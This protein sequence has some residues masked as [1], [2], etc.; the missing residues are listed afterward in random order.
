[1]KRLLARISRGILGNDGARA[2]RD[3]WI[4]A[5]VP[6]R[7]FADVGGLWGT[8]NEKISVA[9][10]AGA[11]ATTMIDVQAPGSKWWQLF[12]QRCRELGVGGYASVTAD[13]CRREV[14][15]KLGRFDIVHCSGIM[16]HVPDML[17]FLRNLHHIT[18]SHLILTSMV[19][20]E[21]VR[22]SRGTLRLPPGTVLSVP[23]MGADSR[24]VMNRHFSD[25]DISIKDITAPAPRYLDN[26]LRFRTGP[27]WWLY[28]AAT[29]RALAGV[30]PFELVD[31]GWC[32]TGKT[33]SLLLRARH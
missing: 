31:E 2:D 18:G 16:Y 28:S 23:A 8:V 30:L 22:N 32:V 11:S 12:D 1:M 27:W 13:I 20:P 14:A 4:R 33:W 24:A 9:T 21:V 6:G 7:S 5:L 17:A 3:A 26:G 25:L 29:M 10:R 15:R 19:V